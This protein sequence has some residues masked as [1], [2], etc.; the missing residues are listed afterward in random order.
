VSSE[1][2]I[3]ALQ[4]LLARVRQRAQALRA[5]P[6]ADPIAEPPSA[7][8]SDFEDELVPDSSPR[9]RE[10]SMELE[11]VDD[12]HE[13]LLKTP[14]PESGRQEA[15]A[16]VPLAA[17][18]ELEIES[19]DLV[20]EPGI[21]GPP[22]ARAEPTKPA[23]I[24]ERPT[25]VPVAE[26]TSEL[27]WPP[28]A[29]LSASQPPAAHAPPVVAEAPPPPVVTPVRLMVETPSAPAAPVEVFAQ[30]FR[31]PEHAAA[32]VSVFIGEVKSSVPRTFG[33]MLDQTLAL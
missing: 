20:P 28:V 8:A 30:V 33:E 23:A 26:V 31:A 3:S 17:A 11:V 27:S 4:A 25:P 32:S 18:P 19:L 14:P 15:A 13:V 24:T 12:E 10:D 7:V 6:E 5:A 9:R 29:D 21:V 1:S 22:E 16:P 2:R